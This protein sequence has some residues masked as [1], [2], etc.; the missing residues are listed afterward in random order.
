MCLL[1]DNLYFKKLKNCHRKKVCDKK[2]H[3]N[4][5]SVK[6]LAILQYMF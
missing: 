1:N 6:D 4:I 2:C 3:L 5:G